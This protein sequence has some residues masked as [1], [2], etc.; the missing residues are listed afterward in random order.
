MVD[1]LHKSVKNPQ[2]STLPGVCA[3]CSLTLQLLQRWNFE[4]MLPQRLALANRIWDGSDKTSRCEF[5]HAP[6]LCLG[7]LTLSHEQAWASLLG[8]GRHVAIS[9]YCLSRQQ[10]NSQTGK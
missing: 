3:L 7:I 8:D 9:L 6:A 4:S 10:T 1:W 5:L 2:F